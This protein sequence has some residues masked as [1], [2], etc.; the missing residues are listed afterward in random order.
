MEAL[1]GIDGAFSFTIGS[2]TAGV[3]SLKQPGTLVRLAWLDGV[4]VAASSRSVFRLVRENMTDGFRMALSVVP[5]I[6]AIGMLGLLLARYTPLFETW[7]TCF[8]H[9]PG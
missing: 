3:D 7:A 4:Q 6:L 9:L 5:S 2:T 1:T 8:F